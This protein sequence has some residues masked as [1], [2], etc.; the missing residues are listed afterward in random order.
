[1]TALTSSKITLFALLVLVLL[2]VSS[3]KGVE[4]KSSNCRPN[5]A[6]HKH[7]KHPHFRAK[8]QSTSTAAQTAQDETPPSSGSASNSSNSGS[9]RSSDSISSTSTKHTSSGKSITPG[10]K[11]GVAGGQSLKWTGADLCWMTDWTPA[12]KNNNYLGKLT[13]ASMLWGLGRVGHDDDAKRF[14][15]FKKI[16]PGTYDYVIGFNEADFQG[17]GSSGVIEPA[18]AAKAW[19]QYIAPHGEAGAVL[20][21]PSCAKQK[22]ENWL[23]PFLKA[24]KRQPDAI[25]VHIFQ[26]SIEGVKGVLD[27]FAQYN[28]PLWITE[29]ACINYQVSPTVY[30]SQQ[31]TDNLI[32]QAIKLF[33]SDDRVAAY[34]ISDAY[35]GP[36]S[37]LTPDHDGTSLSKT[38]KVFIAAVQSATSKSKR[39]L[40]KIVRRASN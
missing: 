4:A 21:S 36:N 15:E 6:T 23:A 5:A 25:N 34:A 33:E 35:N 38:G 31:D 8:Q 7:I 9:A 18:D 14:A 13:V 32:T 11:A 39:S 16:E 20:V 1:M 22:D 10:C 30:C 26:N 12:P 37:A 19:D 27:H 3:P 24:V 29:F 28:K 40:K 2:A 17:S